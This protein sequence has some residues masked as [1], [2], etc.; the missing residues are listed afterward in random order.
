MSL[1]SQIS[2]ELSHVD[3]I[4]TALQ[5]MQTLQHFYLEYSLPDA[6]VAFSSHATVDLPRLAS[7]GLFGSSRDIGV[8]LQHL[9]FPATTTVVL[10]VAM[11]DELAEVNAGGGDQAA[12]APMPLDDNPAGTT[13]AGLIARSFHTIIPPMR[14]Q[15]ASPLHR[16]TE[17]DIALDSE[18]ETEINGIWITAECDNANSPFTFTFY[19]PH[20]RKWETGSR[21]VLRGALAVLASPHLRELR[22]T[23]HRLQKHD[24]KMALAL[25]PGLA[26][27]KIVAV[28]DAALAL[29]GVLAMTRP[30]QEPAERAGLE[31]WQLVLPTLTSL[32]LDNV[33]ED[34][35]EGHVDLLCTMLRIRAQA[36]R[37]LQELDISASFVH[38]AAVE[39]LQAAC[40]GLVVKWIDHLKDDVQEE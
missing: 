11:F 7:L 33:D 4:L 28:E 34:E 35:F 5:R 24:W 18:S 13:V 17:L 6:N 38:R 9:S 36:G 1:N 19:G 31:P 26:I 15:S 27:Q 25:M 16:I 14:R 21:G 37:P 8:L 10:E 22:V 3:E 2:E 32:T 30:A 29:C 39:K 23:D 20:N 12:P 40:P